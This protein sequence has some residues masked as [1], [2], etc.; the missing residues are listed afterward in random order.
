M[1]SGKPEFDPY[2]RAWNEYAAGDVIALD[3]IEAPLFVDMPDPKLA[4]QVAAMT[5]GLSAEA[6]KWM[7]LPDA[8]PVAE[9]HLNVVGGRPVGYDDASGPERHVMDVMTHF[10]SQHLREL[11]EP[12]HGIGVYRFGRVPTMHAHVVPRTGYDDGLDWTAPRMMIPLR[13][14]QAVRGRIGFEKVP[15]QAARLHAEITS[16]L[17]RFV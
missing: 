7:I 1:I 12:E 13:D 2:A 15:G 5:P 3:A 14:R 17:L 4:E 6:L 8:K 10:T 9:N 11:L 16:A